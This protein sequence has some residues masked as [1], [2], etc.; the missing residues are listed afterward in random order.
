MGSAGE[1]DTIEGVGKGSGTERDREGKVDRRSWGWA[2]ARA[3]R[4]SGMGSGL[5]AEAAFPLPRT[6]VSHTPPGSAPTV[7]DICSAPSVPCSLT[8][9][10][11]IPLAQG[12]H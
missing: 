6:L 3:S 5:E 9:L 4:G 11:F 1:E 7:P 8:P 2:G 10:F 12:H